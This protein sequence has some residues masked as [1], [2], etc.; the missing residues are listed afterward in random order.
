MSIVYNPEADLMAEIERLEL[1]ARDLRRRIER[2]RTRDDKRV[3]NKQLGEI[4]DQIE[5]LKT[6]L[7]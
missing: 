6:R 5:V 2:A 4:E 3:L 1:S 7:P